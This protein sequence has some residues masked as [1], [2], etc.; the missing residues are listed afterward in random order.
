MITPP[1]Q[2]TAV[3]TA[4]VT[5]RLRPLYITAFF[6]GFVLWYAIE[7]L[8]MKSIGISDAGIAIIIVTFTSVMMLTNIP[9]GILADRW[10]RKGVLALATL[11]LVLS[12]IVDG[13]STNFWAYLAGSCLWGIFFACY[14]GTYDSVVYD[15]LIEETGS[16]NRFE[17]YFGKVQLF[18]G[19]ALVL[20]SLAS[21]VIAHFF[22]LRD[23]Y[24][25]TAPVACLS[26]VALWYFKEPQL[27]K[28]TAR[29]LLG[30][31]I[32][33]TVRAVV[34]RKEILWLA[35]SFITLTLT[36]RLILEFEQ[37]W[38]IALTLPLFLYGPVNALL[39]AAY[40]AAGL[41]ANRIKGRRLVVVCLAASMVIAS[42]CLLFHV[43]SLIVIAEF[44]IVLG[45][46]VLT[47]LISRWLHDELPSKIRAGAS[48]TV[49]TIGYALFLP[50]GLLF[51]AISRATDVF[52][53]GWI[54]VAV[55]VSVGLTVL[56]A[57]RR[58]SSVRP[59]NQEVQATDP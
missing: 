59:S 40:G 51:G 18:D 53:A 26:F 30:T 57:S 6:Q 29:S 17:Y 39:L 20:S 11:S 9:L 55:S 46:A 32:Q 12:T 56:V 2:P 43:L 48:S 41:V 1:S 15:T 5:R 27:H 10:S 4:S 45:M 50:V 52:R 28:K 31:H 42:I 33:E 54:V 21:A 44:V 35:L 47:I 16:S 38:L 58:M 19:I 34:G 23:V 7:K 3:D 37:L 22:N 13:L 8:F 49:T 14:A 24:F 36:A 25:I